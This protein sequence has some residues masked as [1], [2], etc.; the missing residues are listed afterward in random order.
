MSRVIY[1]FALGIASSMLASCSLAEGVIDAV[2]DEQM[3]ASQQRMADE[4]AEQDRQ[5]QDQEQ[6]H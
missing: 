6:S 1:L 5:K 2:V 3:K 4:M